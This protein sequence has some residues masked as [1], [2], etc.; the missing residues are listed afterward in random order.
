MEYLHSIT[1]V[2]ILWSAC[3]CETFYPGCLAKLS[4]LC[5]AYF[6]SCC[7]EKSS[8]DTEEGCPFYKTPSEPSYP[9]CLKPDWL[10]LWTEGQIEDRSRQA[11]K[12]IYQ[13]KTGPSTD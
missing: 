7:E 3:L 6:E 4:K 1:Y 9:I 13:E 10:N 11:Q 2:T 5:V 12:H 8:N